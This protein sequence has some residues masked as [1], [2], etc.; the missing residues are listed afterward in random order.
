[1]RWGTIPGKIVDSLMMSFDYKGFQIGKTQFMHFFL[2]EKDS[3]YVTLIHL[4]IP[5]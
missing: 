5:V 1:M 3:L 2:F 4:E